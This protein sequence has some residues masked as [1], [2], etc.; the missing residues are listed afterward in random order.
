[1]CQKQ[2]FI[3]NLINCEKDMSTSQSA[4]L[5]TVYCASKHPNY[6]ACAKVTSAAFRL[7][8]E[9]HINKQFA[10]QYICNA[11]R[12]WWPHLNLPSFRLYFTTNVVFFFP[13]AHLFVPQLRNSMKNDVCLDQGP[14]NDNTPILYL[15]HGL[16]PQVRGAI[17]LRLSLRSCGNT[18][19]AFI[20][21]PCDSSGGVSLHE[22]CFVSRPSCGFTSVQTRSGNGTNCSV[23]SETPLKKSHAHIKLWRQLA[24]IFL[25]ISIKGHV[26]D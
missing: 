20:H 17:A 16:T 10:N 5:G 6:A 9:R 24:D 26:I 1:M 8:S 21:Q 25:K 4:V 11:T 3:L 14:D 7:C 15:C 13:L 12:F 2:D 23:L 22:L 18:H 19:P